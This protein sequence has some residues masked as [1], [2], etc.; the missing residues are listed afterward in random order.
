MIDTNHMHLLLFLIMHLLLHVSIVTKRDISQN[1]VIRRKSLI[2]ENGFGVKKEPIFQMRKRKNLSLLKKLVD[3]G[4]SNVKE[5]IN[6]SNQ[7]IQI[8]TNSSEVLESI[9]VANRKGRNL[10]WGPKS[11]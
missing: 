11:A 7:K 6:A 10:V 2:L 4:C 9:K 3:I 1:F 8:K 5:V